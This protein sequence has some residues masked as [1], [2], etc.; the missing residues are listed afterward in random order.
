M[1]NPW[2]LSDGMYNQFNRYVELGVLNPDGS[3]NEDWVKGLDKS[4]AYEMMTGGFGLGDNDLHRAIRGQFEALYL[5]QF[6]G[7]T[8]PDSGLSFGGSSGD[9]GTTP[10]YTVPEIPDSG[11][12]APSGP[13]GAFDDLLD[14]V[15][16]PDTIKPNTG[17]AQPPVAPP[18]PPV[19]DTGTGT[20]PPTGGT[21]P[22]YTGTPQPDPEVLDPPVPVQPTPEWDPGAEL[23]FTPTGIGGGFDWNWEEAQPGAPSLEGGGGYDPN[24]YAFD[25]Y[26]PGQESPWG[27]PDIEGGNRD[28]YRNQF[29]NLLRDE[30]NFQNKQDTARQE[31]WLLDRARQGVQEA[32]GSMSQEN[33][34]AWL[35]SV[36]PDKADWSWM[37]E[38]WT[39]EADVMDNGYASPIR[40]LTTGDDWGYQTGANS[41]AYWWNPLQGDWTTKYGGSVSGQNPADPR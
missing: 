35:G 37:G 25:R 17:G 1:A 20:V 41:A 24:D 2:D 14:A 33:W 7:Q 9:G 23:D 18:Q 29:V 12:S 31:R 3:V 39:P 10:T 27:I 4:D 22:P 36:Q 6:A 16:N 19:I 15:Q 8:T 13:S 5:N 21:Q 34:D 40:G 30:Q 28:F 32:P 11:V 26:V 38:G